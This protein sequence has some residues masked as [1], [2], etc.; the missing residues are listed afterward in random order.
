[1][2]CHRQVDQATAHRGEI[3]KWKCIDL[4]RHLKCC[5][6]SRKPLRPWTQIW[7]AQASEAACTVGRC[8]RF[9]IAA[10][11]T[12]AANFFENASIKPS[13]LPRADKTKI[14][15]TSVSIWDA[16]KRIRRLVSSGR[17]DGYP[18]S[19]SA[20][21]VQKSLCTFTDQGDR[22]VH[23]AINRTGQ[24][25]GAALYVD[26]DASGRYAR[27]RTY[28]HRYISCNPGHI[29]WTS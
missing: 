2:Q 25:S 22:S 27:L 8:G 4:F 28:A 9:A 13:L 17:A 23:L 7:P 5:G 1:M 29:T 6:R 20:L 14:E 12:R 19:T 15:A 21:D 26:P 10:D 3:Q 24:I 18:S 16:Q 11:R